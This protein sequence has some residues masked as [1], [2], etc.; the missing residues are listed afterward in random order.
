MTTTILM[1]SALLIGDAAAAQQSLVRA[2]ETYKIAMPGALRDGAYALSLKLTLDD[3]ERTEKRVKQ[4]R[5]LVEAEIV[6]RSLA[7]RGE[8][9]TSCYCGRAGC[10]GCGGNW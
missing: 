9:Q 10:N 5:T 4:L 1:T 7:E 6:K 3:I 8:V 2:D